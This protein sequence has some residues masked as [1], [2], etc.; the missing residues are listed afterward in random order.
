MKGLEIEGK[1]VLLNSERGVV[2]T[3]VHNMRFERP[4]RKSPA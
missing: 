2:K 4:Q 3:N 1:K